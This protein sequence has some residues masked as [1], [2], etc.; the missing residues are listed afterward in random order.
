MN[1]WAGDESSSIYCPEESRIECENG[2]YWIDDP[3][4]KNDKIVLQTNI[5]KR[6]GKKKGRTF[7][8]DRVQNEEIRDFTRTP[9]NTL[10]Q[11]DLIS[12]L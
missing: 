8:H 12:L 4:F 3:R 7:L 5:E 2:K 1:Y 11:D 9:R 6:T 10:D